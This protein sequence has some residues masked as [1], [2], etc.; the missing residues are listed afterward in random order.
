MDFTEQLRLLEAARGDPAL[1]ALATV[2]FAHGSLTDTDRA[3]IKEALIASAVPHWCDRDILAALL[4]RPV[5]A[6]DPLIAQLAVLAV[7]E[8]RPRARGTCR[9]RPRSD[10]PRAA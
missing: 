5:E 6:A 10:P 8:P 1:L 9:E 7:V 3:L 2:D 4:D